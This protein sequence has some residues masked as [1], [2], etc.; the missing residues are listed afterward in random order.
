V[1][2]I[3]VAPTAFGPDGLLGGGERY[4]LELARALARERDVSCELV[5]FGKRA[6]SVSDPSGLRVRLLRAPWR[7][8]GHPAQPVA[9]ALPGAVAGA[10]LV[11]AHHVHCVPSAVAAL[12]ARVTRGR[13]V[14]TDHGMPPGLLAPLVDRLFQR[15]LT[16]SE[17]SARML[18]AP[19]EKVRV[20]LGGV[21][22]EL[23]RP[24]WSPARDFVLF[25]GRVTPHKG[26]DVLLRALPEGARLAV[27]GSV[28]HDPRPPERDYPALLGKLAEGREVSFLGP[29]PDDQL[30]VLYGQAAALVLPSVEETCYGRRHRV[31]ELLGLTAL[32][33]MACGTPVVASGL[34]GLRE[35]VDDGVTGFLFPPGDHARLRDHLTRLLGDR[36]LVERLG[37]AARE[38]V[39]QGWTWRHCARRCLAAYHELVR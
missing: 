39:L 16:V 22:P 36:A 38:R 23:F 5:T 18:G 2:V 25:V 30:A 20:V 1:R 31:S 3:H 17:Y 37:G 13:A 4:P 15:Y 10:D 7:Q 24:V 32:E 8:G 9:P 33:A 19:S 21:D 29:L 28:G 35:V 11:H 27:V 14:A 34:G 26:I 6:S 12:A